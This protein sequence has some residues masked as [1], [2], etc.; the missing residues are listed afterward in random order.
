MMYRLDKIF[1]T[2]Y[3]NFTSKLNQF[4][5]RHTHLRKCF[6]LVA[7]LKTIIMMNTYLNF[8]QDDTKKLLSKFDFEFF[9]TQNI[10]KQSYSQSDIDKIYSTRKQTVQHIKLK[11][12]VNKKQFN[13]YAEGQVRKM[14]TGGLLQSIFELDESRG[15]K[16]NDF[17]A[18]G[19]N[20]TYFSYW[21]VYQKRKITLKEIWDIIIKTGSL[22][23]IVLSVIKLFEYLN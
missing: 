1:S 9:L 17:S 10:D 11:S 22:L 14:F 4:V 16:I 19:E 23:G 8:E 21:K 5:A 13:Y 12:Q 18:T 20:W 3:F 6:S 7:R 15:Y 2:F